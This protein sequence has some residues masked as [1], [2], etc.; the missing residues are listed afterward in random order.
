MKC[1]IHDRSAVTKSEAKARPM[2]SV[3]AFSPE[4]TALYARKLVT[5][6]A[7]GSGDFTNAMERVGRRCGMTGRAMRRLINGETK[8]P[9]LRVFARVRSAYLD[10]CARQI[11]QLQAELDA[12]KARYGDAAFADIE[13]EVSTLVAK[14]QRAKEGLK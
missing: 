4:Q 9:G 12:D 10:L 13:D 6:E 3:E 2:S 14:L 1:Q 7:A 11:A 8:D 5:R